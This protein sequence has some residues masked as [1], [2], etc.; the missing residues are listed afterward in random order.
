[1]TYTAVAPGAAI[2]AFPLRGSGVNGFLNATVVLFGFGFVRNVFPL[3]DGIFVPNDLVGVVEEL[4][5][6]SKEKSHFNS[7]Q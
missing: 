5:S 4:P 3:N 7:K 6:Y 1:M 2:E